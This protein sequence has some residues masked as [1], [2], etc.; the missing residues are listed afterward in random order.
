ML[1]LVNCEVVKREY[2]QA[3]S[4]VYVTNHIVD[5]TDGSGARVA[6]QNYY[7]G[8]SDDYGYLLSCL[9]VLC[10]FINYRLILK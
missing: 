3:H 5:A 1:H 10:E 6:I 4:D 8:K 2:M 7:N 9:C